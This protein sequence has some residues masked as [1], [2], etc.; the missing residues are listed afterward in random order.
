MGDLQI[1]ESIMDFL[2]FYNLMACGLLYVV[3]SY[4]IACQ[5]MQNFYRCMMEYPASMQLPAKLS[6]KFK[7]P[8]FYLP[9]HEL[10]CLT[11]FSFNYTEG[12]GKTDGEG[13]ERTWSWLNG[14]ACSLSMMTAGA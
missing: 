13:V 6:M 3:F 14:C 1:G 9:A 5:W 7:V 12:V 2:A 4:D 8:K 11:K 10:S